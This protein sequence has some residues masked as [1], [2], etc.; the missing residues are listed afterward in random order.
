MSEKTIL[1]LHA[2]GDFEP[3]DTNIVQSEIAGNYSFKGNEIIVPT[4]IEYPP[5][6]YRNYFVEKT[7][8][9]GHITDNGSV[10]PPQEDERTSDFIDVKG[11]DMV[12]VRIRY[13]NMT[14]VYWAWGGIYLYDD[15]K[16]YLS[17]YM[18]EYLGATTGDHLFEIKLTPNVAYLRLYT[19]YYDTA[20]V[21]VKISVERGNTANTKHYLAPEDMPSWVV[22]TGNPISIFPEG[23]VIKGDLILPTLSLFS[24]NFNRADSDTLGGGW[25]VEEG[26]FSIVN[27]TAKGTISNQNNT[28]FVDVGESD[29][30]SISCRIS[31]FKSEAILLRCVDVNNYILAIHELGVLHIRIKKNGATSTFRSYAVNGTSHTTRVELRGTEIKVFNNGVLLMTYTTDEFLTATKFGFKSWT[32]SIIVSNTVSIG[33]FDEFTVSR[34]LD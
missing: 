15:N 12:T 32:D 28:A 6:G 31:P 20:N 21:E 16:N 4:I 34:L 3:I 26:G 7:S 5:T 19:T 22:D 24:D 17:T 2:N 18:D 33:H 1:K 9:K 30:L 14:G 13:K 8:V 25:T 29:N 23:I 10:V 27:G 11:W